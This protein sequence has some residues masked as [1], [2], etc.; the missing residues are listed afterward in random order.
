MTLQII[1]IAAVLVFLV[2]V[3][4]GG[5]LLRSHYLIHRKVYPA[6]PK[7]FWF[8]IGSAVVAL[9]LL[10]IAMQNWWYS[11][12]VAFAITMTAGYAII[13]HSVKPNRGQM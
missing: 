4:T 6:S 12:M 8:L 5:D 7:Y 2:S 10:T 11:S 3:M 13:S 1:F 9:V